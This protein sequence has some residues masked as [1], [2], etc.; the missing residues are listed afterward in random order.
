M[1]K[2]KEEKI[3]VKELDKFLVILECRLDLSG[4][5]PN[6]PY[7]WDKEKILNEVKSQ[8]NNAIDCR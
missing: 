5:F 7:R 4:L 3:L 8:I 6:E 2:K 1:L